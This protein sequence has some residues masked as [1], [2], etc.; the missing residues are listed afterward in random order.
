MANILIFG[1]TQ[2]IGR[3]LVEELIKNKIHEITLCNRGISNL[4]IFPSVNRIKCDRN[5]LDKECKN[6]FNEFYDFV[7]DFSGYQEPQLSNISKYLRCHKYIYISSIA[8]IRRQIDSEMQNYANNKISCEF[9]IK[10]T[11]P[12]YCI[13]RPTYVVGDYDY[14]NRFYKKNNEFYWLNTETKLN[15]Y[16]TTNELNKILLNE[17]DFSNCSKTIDCEKIN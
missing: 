17:I 4:D 6:I 9:F 2:F 13:V 16:I 10:K 15:D 7:F 3:S 5:T 12:N 8:V 11:Y 14:S 1:G